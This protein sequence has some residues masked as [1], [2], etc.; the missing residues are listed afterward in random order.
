M[1]TTWISSEQAVAPGAA[2]SRHPLFDYCKAPGLC[3]AECAAGAT[4][5]E[6]DTS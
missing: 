5:I 4:E 3:V 1:T 6:L 2:L